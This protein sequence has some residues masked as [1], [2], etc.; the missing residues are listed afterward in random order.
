[1]HEDISLVLLAT[2]C[3]AAATGE[4]CGLRQRREDL[5][6]NSLCCRY[7][8]IGMGLFLTACCAAATGEVCGLRQRREDLGQKH[9]VLQI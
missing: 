8:G 2:A 4:V 3:C 7:E 9:A 1:V 5:G 6:R